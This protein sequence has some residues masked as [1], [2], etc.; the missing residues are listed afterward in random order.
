APACASKKYV[1]TTVN[2]RAAPLE[3]RATELESGIRGLK[4]QT[5]NLENQTN[6]L[7]AT[8]KK[9][10]TDL[11]DLDERSMRGIEDAKEEATRQA[12]VAKKESLAETA[13][14]DCRVNKLDNWQEQQIVTI[15]FKLNQHTLTNESKAKLDVIVNEILGQNG[16]I[17]EVKGFTDATGSVDANRKL[18]QLR[19]QSVF[20]YLVEKDVPSYKINMVGVGEIKP[21]SDNKTKSGRAENR[22]VEIRLLVNEGIKANQ[23]NVLP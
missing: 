14:V 13:K 5:D 6:A 2:E 8:T 3:G 4:G 18:S 10:Q 17:L 9:L 12:A 7:D 20:Q 19:A 21:I 15:N 1:R 11:S 16:Y 22:R 23:L